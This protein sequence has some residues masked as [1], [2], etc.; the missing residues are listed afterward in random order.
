MARIIKA[1]IPTSLI[2]A[3]NL[4]VGQVLHCLESMITSENPQKGWILGLLTDIETVKVVDENWKLFSINC[5]IFLALSLLSD[6]R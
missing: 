2:V 3:V 6:G 5:M 4:F 1:V